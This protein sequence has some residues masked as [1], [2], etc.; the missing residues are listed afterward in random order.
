M[1]SG[2]GGPNPNT[3]TNE[4]VEIYNTSNS[5]YTV[6]SFSGNGLALVSL[7]G[8]TRFVIPNGTVIPPHGH[9][10]AVNP[11]GYALDNYG[12]AG[13]AAGDITY[14]TDIP[15]NVGIALFNTDFPVEFTLANRL[16]AVGSTAEANTLYKEGTGYPP[17]TNFAIDF[18]WRRKTYAGPPQDTDDNNADFEYGDTNG[19]SAGAGQRLG[20]AG[21]ENL[22]SP[23]PRDAGIVV[24]RLDE[25][26]APD[27]PPNAVRI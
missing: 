19:T 3:S 11:T 18:Y 9:Y 25:T 14:S 13:A 24:T 23:V 20:A 1:N 4:Y 7:D 8:I 16:D 21:P 2:S 26:I 6:S 22:S 27:L 17:L 15:N 10:L 5:A 12:G